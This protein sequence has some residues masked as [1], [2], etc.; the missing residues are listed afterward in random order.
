MHRMITKEGQYIYSTSRIESAHCIC[1][2][3]SLAKIKDEFY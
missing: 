3:C 2:L 1:S